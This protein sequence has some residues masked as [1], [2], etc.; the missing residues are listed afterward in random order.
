[1]GGSDGWLK[2][3]WHVCVSSEVSSYQLVKAGK[4]WYIY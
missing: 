2:I 1:M 4:G 3:Y